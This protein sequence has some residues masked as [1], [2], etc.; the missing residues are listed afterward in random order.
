MVGT[1]IPKTHDPD[2]SHFAKAPSPINPEM[3]KTRDGRGLHASKKEIDKLGKMVLKGPIPED[4]SAPT[5]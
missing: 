4:S 1:N 5:D 2:Y 3:A